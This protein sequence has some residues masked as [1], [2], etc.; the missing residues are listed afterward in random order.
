MPTITDEQLVQCYLKER[1]EQALEALVKRYTPRIYGFVRTFI[2]DPDVTS[3]ITQETFVKVWKN[4]KRFDQHQN[5]KTW[6]FTIAKHT[7]IDWLRKCGAVPL[8]LLEKEGMDIAENIADDVPTLL[9]QLFSK[10]KDHEL[11]VALAQ[12]PTS[13]SSV[14]HQ[15]IHE[16]LN[17]RE[18]AE[19]TGESLNTI[20]SRYRRGLILLK[21]LIQH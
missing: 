1:N 9:E 21:K 8:S 6:L 12:L 3:D 19:A 16:G 15:H 18:L 11:T 10:E 14:I 2:G 20:K 5:F 4:L 7:A 17:F 13:H